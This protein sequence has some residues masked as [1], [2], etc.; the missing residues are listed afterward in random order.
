MSSCRHHRVARSFP[1]ALTRRVAVAVLAFAVIGCGG[2]ATSR[3]PPAAAYEFRTF[4]TG[5]GGTSVPLVFRWPSG[6]L[7][8]RIWV[9]AD[10]PRRPAL[11]RAID[12]WE[13]AL[14]SNQFRATLVTSPGAADIVLGAQPAGGRGSASRIRLEGVADGCFGFTDFSVDLEAGTL[15]LPFRIEVTASP[16]VAAATLLSCYDAT[17]LHELGH[18]LGIFAHSPNANDVMH[19][20]PTRATLSGPDEA[21]VAVLY[22]TDPTLVP[23]SP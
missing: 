9:A 11:I 10:D 2:D 12:T 13:D 19:T 21:T 7:P 8:V 17:V 14:R 16:G 3:T 18:A 22:G 15:T 5:P 6:A 23:V 4:A 1:S 20:D